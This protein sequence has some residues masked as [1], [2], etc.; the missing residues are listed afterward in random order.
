VLVAIS[1]GAVWLW[2]T[3]TNLSRLTNPGKIA[4]VIS[5][6]DTFAVSDIYSVNANGSGLTNLTNH[7]AGYGP[8]VWSPDN[9]QIAFSSSRENQLSKIYIMNADGSGLH[10]LTNSGDDIESSPAWSPDG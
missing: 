5:P 10:R 3:G 2:E 6:D 7:P 8:P 4:L 9:T 1:I